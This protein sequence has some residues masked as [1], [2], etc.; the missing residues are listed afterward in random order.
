MRN[1]AREEQS[2]IVNIARIET[3][4][5]EE[6]AGMVERHQHHDE[7]AQQIDQ[8]SQTRPAS[9]VP[10]NQD[11]AGAKVPAIIGEVAWCSNLLATGRF[12]LA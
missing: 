11:V 1:P 10:P 7:A 3:A 6:V 12:P 2:R 4:G 8:S 9:A 5:G